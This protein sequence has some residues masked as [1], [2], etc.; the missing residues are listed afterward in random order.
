MT[1]TLKLRSG[2]FIKT[3]DASVYFVIS[4]KTIA[5]SPKTFGYLDKPCDTCG[6]R[7]NYMLSLSNTR[8]PAHFCTNCLD[9]TD[10][11]KYRTRFGY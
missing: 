1:T 10:A 3:A 2:S 9:L 4:L 7:T 6:L 5:S 11:V 8:T